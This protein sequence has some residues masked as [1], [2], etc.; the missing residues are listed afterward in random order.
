MSL[1]KD[2]GT[3]TIYKCKGCPERKS[4][5][6]EDNKIL[7][8]EQRIRGNLWFE[9][10]CTS[11]SNPPA[12]SLSSTADQALDFDANNMVSFAELLGYKTRVMFVGGCRLSGSEL[13]SCKG[14][15]GGMC[16]V[17]NL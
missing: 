12:S 8:P 6:I 15:E 11:S 4:L 5:Q 1:F 13:R 7:E 2:N 17:Y 14:G 16:C 9:S 10:L 3:G